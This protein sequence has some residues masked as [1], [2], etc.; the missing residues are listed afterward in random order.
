MML[1]ECQEL[2]KELTNLAQQ[3]YWKDRRD[4]GS[5]MSQDCVDCQHYEVCKNHAT[6][7]RILSE[8]EKRGVL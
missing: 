6:I 3:A 7:R 4:C 5:D 1:P 2:F 8:A